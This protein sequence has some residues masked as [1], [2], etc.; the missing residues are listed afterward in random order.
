M[1]RQ[2]GTR[3]TTGCGHSWVR[4]YPKWK[5]G[6]L[7]GA[8][9]DCAYVV[10]MPTGRECGELLII[11]REQFDGMN[12]DVFPAEVH[13]PLFHRYMNEQDVRWPADGAGTGYVEFSTDEQEG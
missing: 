3:F 2:Y 9:T 7:M 5:I 10:D 13:M 4:L 11:P 1:K 8:T 12:P 6:D